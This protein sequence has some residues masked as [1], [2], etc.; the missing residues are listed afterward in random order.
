MNLVIAVL[1]ENF[2]QK[3]DENENNLKYKEIE[4][5]VDSLGLSLKVKELF[6]NNSFHIVSKKS[7][8]IF[9]ATLKTFIHPIKKFKS[10]TVPKSE[11]YTN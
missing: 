9:G 11:L 1:F 3:Q 10:I 6:M 7:H 5:Y 8:L 4:N 2:N